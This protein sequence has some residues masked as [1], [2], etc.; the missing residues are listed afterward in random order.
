[1]L[2]IDPNPDK[3]LLGLYCS[4]KLLLVQKSRQ[5]GIARN[6]GEDGSPNADQ[7][8]VPWV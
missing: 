5:K 2:E 8:R 4:Q 7:L 3:H 1:M 6:G